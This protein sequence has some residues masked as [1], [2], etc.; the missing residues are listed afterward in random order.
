[1]LP[2]SAQ[3][4]STCPPCPYCG[5]SVTVN[6]SVGETYQPPMYFCGGCERNWT[7]ERRKQTMV[8]TVERRVSMSRT[9]LTMPK[10]PS[11]VAPTAPYPIV[12]PHAL[13]TVN[14]A[15]EALQKAFQPSDE[16]PK[17]EQA[18]VARPQE[19]SQDPT[20]QN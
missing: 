6:V 3:I 20:R 2:L 4:D 10:R 1:M 7:V 18:G 15:L 17:E 14:D 12:D 9:I 19:P 5:S 13:T 16:T 11:F 8:V